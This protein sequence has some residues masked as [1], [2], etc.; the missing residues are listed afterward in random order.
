MGSNGTWRNSTGASAPNVAAAA[1]THSSTQPRPAALGAE[2]LRQQG[3]ATAAGQSQS[4]GHRRL[5]L[6]AAA[7]RIAATEP[8]R[9]R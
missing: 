9:H 1:S 5:L 3:V 7:A 2:A 6:I 8:G 4:A